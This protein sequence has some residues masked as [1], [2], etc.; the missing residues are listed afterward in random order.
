MPKNN[1]GFSLI[2]LL[3]VVMLLSLL[4][5]LLVPALNPLF[6]T[7]ARQGAYQ[8]NSLLAKAKVYAMGRSDEVYIRIYVQD[9]RVYG[10]HLIVGKDGEKTVLSTEQLAT[11]RSNVYITPPVG[12]SP[13]G[14][15]GDTDEVYISFQRATGALRVFGKT[16]APP[17]TPYATGDTAIIS[18][19]AGD[20][21][22]EVVII[23]TTGKHEV[24]Q[25]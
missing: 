14:L 21:V 6:A 13:Y 7:E 8:I 16:M 1:R 17:T 2:E 15:L 18:T 23:A 19:A 3:V 25:P 20:K 24:T 5:G 11:K 22:Y 4:V 10:D 9:N 12:T